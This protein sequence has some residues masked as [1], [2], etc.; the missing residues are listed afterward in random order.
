M[1][2]NTCCIDPALQIDLID[3]GAGRDPRYRYVLVYIDHY[4]RYAWLFPLVTKEPY[5]V[6]RA[7][8]WATEKALLVCASACTLYG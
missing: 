4:S 8:C 5:L 2:S 3:L 7:V 1:Q 6:V